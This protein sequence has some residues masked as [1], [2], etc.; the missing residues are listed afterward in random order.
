MARQLKFVAPMLTDALVF[1][2][3]CPLD[4]TVTLSGN[5]QAK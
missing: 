1:T 4:G 5:L 3:E 2:V